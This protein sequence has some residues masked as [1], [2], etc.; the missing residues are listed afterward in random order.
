LRFIVSP[1][2][3]FESRPILFPQGDALGWLVAPRLG[4]R[5][6]QMIKSFFRGTGS[7]G[8]VLNDP[9][10]EVFVDVDDIDDSR[11]RHSNRFAAETLIPPKYLG[12]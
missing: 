1:F 9:S 6:F 5:S 4:R 12:R 3:G 11:E 2:Q 7:Q 10:D 8:H